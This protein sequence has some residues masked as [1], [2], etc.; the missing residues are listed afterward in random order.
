ML[1]ILPASP[2][3]YRASRF[4]IRQSARI[5]PKPPKYSSDSRG[6]Q[7]ARSPDCFRNRSAADDR[8]VGGGRHD[9]RFH[10]AA[11]PATVLHE[12]IVCPKAG[13]KNRRKI[14][15]KNRSIRAIFIQP[16]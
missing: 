9:T 7:G 8:A 1:Q 16:C 6:Q 4:F 5:V 2:I 13:V 11:Q 10:A 3:A 14:P 12:S 15:I